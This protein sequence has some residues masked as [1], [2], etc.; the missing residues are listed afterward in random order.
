MT[1]SITIKGT[2]YILYVRTGELFRL[3]PS[4]LPAAGAVR[5]LVKYGSRE[6]IRVLAAMTVA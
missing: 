6:Y 2:D 5:S 3:R 4:G 1:D